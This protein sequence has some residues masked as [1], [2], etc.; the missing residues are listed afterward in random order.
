QLAGMADVCSLSVFEEDDAAALPVPGSLLPPE[1][2][3]PPDA[4]LLAPDTLLS[5]LEAFDRIRT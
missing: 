3:S 4:V 1:T 2:V 5:L